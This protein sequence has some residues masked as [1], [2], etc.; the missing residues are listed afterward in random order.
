MRPI[1]STEQGVRAHVHD[2]IGLVLT[3]IAIIRQGVNPAA[4][5]T[6]GSVLALGRTQDISNI[7]GCS[8]SSERR[9]KSSQ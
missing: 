2:D 9:R 3:S 6:T 7:G 8:G 5:L 1:A 4:S